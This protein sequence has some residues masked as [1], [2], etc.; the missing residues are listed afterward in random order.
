MKRECVSKSLV[1]AVTGCALPAL[2][3]EQGVLLDEI[4]ITAQKRTEAL[5]EVPASVQLLRGIDL[6]STGARDLSTI[7]NSIPGASMGRSLSASARSYQ[8]RGVAGYYG[9]ATVGYYLDEAIFTILNR[10]FGPNVDAFDLERVE[11]L[12]GPQGTLY[13]SGAM[14]GTMRFITADPVLGEFGFRGNL[15]YSLTND[16][17]QRADDN[18]Y[19]NA[20]V[21]VP[22]GEKFALRASAS[23]DLQGGFAGQAPVPR[24]PSPPFPSPQQPSFPDMLNEIEQTGYRVKLLARPT[25][26]FTAKFTYQ[27]Q[28]TKDPLGRQMATID[29]GSYYPTALNGAPIKP[30]A[31][32]EYDMFSLFLAYDFGAFT[33]ESS[34]GYLDRTAE[35]AT[36]LFIPL[37]ARE[38]PVGWTS[39]DSDTLSSELRLVSSSDG[40]WRWIV[41]GIYQDAMAR[42]DIDAQYFGFRPPGLCQGVPVVP[43][44][45]TLGPCT[46]RNDQTQYDSTSYAVFGEISYELFDGK[47][48]PLVGLRY[49]QDDRR[50]RNWV[51]QDAAAPILDTD[52]IAGD[53][54]DFDSTDGR[55]NLA[56]L[57]N[58]NT[59]LYVNIAS[60]FRSGTFNSADGIRAAALS[61][62]PVTVGYAVDPDQLWSYELG[63]KLSF[64]SVS[65]ELAAYYIDWTDVQLNFSG[66]NNVQY[67]ANAGDVVGQGIDYGLNWQITEGLLLQLSGN[68][69][70]TELDQLREGFPESATMRVGEQIHSVPKQTHRV[71]VNYERPLGA[72]GLDFTLYSAYSFTDK[73]GDISDTVLGRMGEA[74]ELLSASIGVRGAKWG[75]RLFGDNLLDERGAI[76]IAGSG[77]MRVY[78]MTYGLE[79]SFDL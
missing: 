53:P 55:F 68:F 76:Q 22:L 62:P 64:G 31:E 15:G 44:P 11:V 60:G 59:M 63:T 57:P 5:S 48:I 25:E 35:A 6:E 46:F 26:E 3:A 65:L 56:W 23:Y 13:G 40:P 78:P 14:G 70:S 9:D 67:I 20:V 36:P 43:G 16:E 42:E 17:G 39:G 38:V 1:L 77:S 10:N 8:I 41:G 74:Q 52:T 27:Y 58:D 7:I 54:G 12:R 73:Q 45:P 79:L 30:Y 21:N 33:L 50:F 24:A 28:N 71:A 29:P 18:Y 32:T 34:S 4:I 69:N 72:T 19:G 51:P 61:T 2:A 75:A 49:F 66:F 47:L 37:P